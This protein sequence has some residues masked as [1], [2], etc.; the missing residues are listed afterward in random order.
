[1]ETYVLQ[2]KQKQDQT[3]VRLE[4]ERAC[5]FQHSFNYEDLWTLS[6]T[7]TQP[8]TMNTWLITRSQSFMTQS[9]FR[10]ERRRLVSHKIIHMFFWG[11]PFVD[12]D[13]GVQSFSFRTS[14]LGGSWWF[15]TSGNML[16]FCRMHGHPWISMWGLSWYWA[17]LQGMHGRTTCRKSNSQ[18]QG[19]WEWAVCTTLPWLS[20]TVL[21]WPTFRRH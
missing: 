10:S 12:L 17:L 19:R 1:M 3:M 21:E 18:N 20:Y 11:S 15:L 16:R 6:R 2:D 8:S 9:T 5:I 14:P 13:G 7:T 4:C